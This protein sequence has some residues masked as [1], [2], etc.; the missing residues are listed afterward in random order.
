ML[1]GLAFRQ[2]FGSGGLVS[3]GG[4]GCEVPGN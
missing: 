4:L 1:G 2:K 3:F